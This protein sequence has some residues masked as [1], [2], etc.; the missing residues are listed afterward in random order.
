MTYIPAA[1][2]HNMGCV[3]NLLFIRGMEQAKER[4]EQDGIGLVHFYEVAG[5]I[6]RICGL[7]YVSEN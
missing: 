2:W 3:V 6:V 7:P 4:L 5:K 1:D